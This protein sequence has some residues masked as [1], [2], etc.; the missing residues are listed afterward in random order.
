MPVT[1]MWKW[2][3]GQKLTVKMIVGGADLDL[4]WE[5]VKLDTNLLVIP[6]QGCA[7]F[8]VVE[9]LGVIGASVPVIVS[10]DVFR[11]QLATGEDPGLGDYVTI[12]VSGEVTALGGASSDIA[13]GTVVDYD[14]ASGSICHIKALFWPNLQYTDPG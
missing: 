14:P 2:Q 8:G 9:P 12:A 6:T 1:E 7:V 10:N 11:V 4:A 5:P 3:R 13:C